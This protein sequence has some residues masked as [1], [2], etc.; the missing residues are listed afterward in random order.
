MYMQ[1]R[2]L[3]TCRYTSMKCCVPKSYIRN[4]YTYFWDK[5]YFINMLKTHNEPVMKIPKVVST[6][7]A[8]HINIRILHKLFQS[9]QY[10]IIFSSNTLLY[11]STLYGH[12]QVTFLCTV[13][14]IMKSAFPHWPVFTRREDV[15]AYICPDCLV[16]IFIE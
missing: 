13:A 6:L 14:L 1:P 16:S 12:L 4:Q 10:F 5:P 8:I 11:V 2:S 3:P 9:T 15:N 7:R